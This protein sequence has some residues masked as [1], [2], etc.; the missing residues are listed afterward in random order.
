VIKHRDVFILQKL[1][2]GIFYFHDN[3]AHIYLHIMMI[4]HIYNFILLYVSTYILSCC[5][6]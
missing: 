5:D 1:S 6:D 4:K 3:D 2:T